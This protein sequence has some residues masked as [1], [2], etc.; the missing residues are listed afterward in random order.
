[1]PMIRMATKLLPEPIQ[2]I[3]FADGYMAV[4]SQ[5]HIAFGDGKSPY[6]SDGLSTCDADALRV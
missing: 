5:R 2:V 3:K 6:L 1:M 4:F